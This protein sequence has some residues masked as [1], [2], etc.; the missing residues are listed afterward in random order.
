M[1]ILLIARV[2][3]EVEW[4]LQDPRESALPYEAIVI[5][6]IVVLNALLGYSSRTGV[7]CGR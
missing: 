5:L 3:S 7:R 4:L 2:I 1:I 6:A